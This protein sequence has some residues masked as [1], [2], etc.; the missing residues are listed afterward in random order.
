MDEYELRPQKGLPHFRYRSIEEQIR[1]ASSSESI[2]RWWWE[3]LRLSKD[4][5]FLCRTCA[6]G[7]PQTYDEKLAQIF[8]DF[9]NVHEGSFED[10]WR[11]TGS[12]LFAEQELPPRVQQI[13]SADTA[14][15]GNR[16]GKIL[17]EIPLQLTRETVQKQISEIL[18]LYS[19]QRPRHRY[20]TSTSKYPIEPVLTRMKVIQQAHEVYCL[21][22]ELIQKPKALARLGVSADLTE[23][24]NKANLFRIGKI[25][26]LSPQN[27]SLVGMPQ[28]VASRTK[29]MRSEVSRVID[30]A[31]TLL[32]YVE[33]GRFA[34]INDDRLEHKPRFSSKQDETH[35]ELEAEWWAL[36]LYSTLSE[37]KIQKA[38]ELH[39]RGD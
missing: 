1:E 5:W 15:P 24:D 14:V 34:V 4:Y 11:R 17:V 13:T 38:R 36:D 32:S 27:V 7:R 28:E 31:E 16:V 39:Y 12:D 22:R 25:Y 3:Y 33:S 6:E 9:G 18:D 19:D 10:W 8:I 21:H 20:E 2:R 30:R 29:K 23:H 35:R 26:G 37:S